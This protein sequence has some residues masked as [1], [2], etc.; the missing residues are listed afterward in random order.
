VEIRR[1]SPYLIV[2]TLWLLVFSSASQTMIIAPILPRI[3]DELGIA[4]AALGT[5]VSA[6]TLMVGLFAILSGPISDKVGRRRILMLG[7]G[8]MTVALTLHAFVTSYAAFLAVRVFAGMAGGILS[9]AAV[10]YI[11][12]Y[13][14]YHRRG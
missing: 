8:T 14:P 11:G 13:F 1:P 4:D 10:S 12:D 7:T 3:G 5:L 6:Y 2:F 9:G